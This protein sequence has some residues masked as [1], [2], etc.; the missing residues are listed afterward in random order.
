G[1]SLLS[2]LLVMSPLV[3][4][5]PPLCTCYR[6]PLTVSCQSQGFTR[7]PSAVPAGGAR[8]FLQNN[9]IE[10]LGAGSFPPNVS[11]LWLY[12]NN[13]SRVNRGALSGLV[14]LEELDLGENVYLRSLEPTTFWGL[15][16]LQTLH[17]HRC[18]LLELPPGLFR[19][20]YAL[21]YLYL[22][23][24]HISQLPDN[25]FLDLANLSYLFLHGN[26]IR[27]LTANA[28][29]GLVS[30]DRLLLHQNRLTQVQRPAFR[31]LRRLA[32][33]FLF[34]NG[35]TELPGTS[36]LPL[37]SLRFL[38][39]NGNPWACDCRARSLW[40]WFRRFP[41]ASSPLTCASPPERRGRDLRLLTPTDLRDCPAEPGAGG[42]WGPADGEEEGPGGLAPPPS[43]GKESREPGNATSGTRLN[44]SPGERDPRP[45]YWPDYYGEGEPT[46]EGPARCPGGRCRSR[47]SIPQAAQLIIGTF[48]FPIWAATA[49]QWL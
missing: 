3:T 17:L 40:Q 33:L 36:L 47:A 26:R 35:L 4:G 13:I 38:R 24:N 23:E 31:D 48:P 28:F 2:L 44:D 34:D 49:L 43:P 7:V 14:Q 27:T 25:L 39:L 19:K 5:C 12:A 1:Y 30:L 37:A 10:E 20:L 16:R 21:Q 18:G 11:I 41:G 6:A 22:Q 29:R 8:V 9:R 42:R 45:D 15:G 46:P 32:T